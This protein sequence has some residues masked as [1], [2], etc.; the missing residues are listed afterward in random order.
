VRQGVEMN[1]ET[2]EANQTVESHWEPDLAPV[3][4]PRWV[5]VLGGINIALAAFGLVCGGLVMLSVPFFAGMVEDQLNGDPLPPHLVLTPYTLGIALFG[6]VLSVVLMVGSILLVMRRFKSR[7]II[8]IYSVLALP[9][10]FLAFLNQINIQA[11]VQQ[12]VKDY[13]NN[14]MANN[15]DTANNAGAAIGQYIGLGLFLLLGLGWPLFMLIWFS[16]IKTKEYHYTGIDPD[17]D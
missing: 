10:N 6:L 12:W 1:D 8:L 13:P 5:P 9:L 11:G 14:P 2:Q 3:N 15:F 7:M 4:R 16:L 17:E